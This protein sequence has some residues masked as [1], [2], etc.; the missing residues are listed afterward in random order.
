[1]KGYYPATAA[2]Q[3]KLLTPVGKAPPKLRRDYY[4]KTANGR[5]TKVITN[6]K[7]GRD[8]VLNRMCIKPVFKPGPLVPPNIRI[9]KPPIR[10]LVLNPVVNLPPAPVKATQ[11]TL[12]P[13]TPMTIQPTPTP[14]RPMTIQ[15]TPTPVK[16][17]TIQ[18]NTN[19]VKPM[20]IQPPPKAAE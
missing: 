15:P 3:A 7:L 13:V 14:V 5:L 2:E 12:T 6:E 20:T 4:Y 9:P 17:M 1:V 8:D 19:P 18:P 16:P 11:P 10:P